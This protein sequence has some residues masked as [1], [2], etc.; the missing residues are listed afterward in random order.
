MSEENITRQFRL[1]NIDETQNYLIEKINQSELMS[2]KHKKVVNC[3]EH[4]LILI[5]T[6]TVYISIYTFASLVDIPVGI[7][8]SAI[9]LKASVIT[10]EVRKRKKSMVKHYRLQN[11]N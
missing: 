11:L 10:A 4:L 5:S 6:V 7:K 2:K 8:S 1:K 3:I 9:G